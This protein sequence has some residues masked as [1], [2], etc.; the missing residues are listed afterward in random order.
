MTLQRE[1]GT[2]PSESWVRAHLAGLIAFTVGLI[3]LAVAAWL[4][5]AG[6]REIT[7]VPDPRVTIPLMAAALVAAGVSLVRRERAY[8]LPVF[9]ASMGVAAIAIGWVIVVGVIA[10]VAAIAVILL[11]ELM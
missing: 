11:S 8:A 4:Q 9:G 6:D 2:P 1:A 3:A 7:D 10:G 5:F